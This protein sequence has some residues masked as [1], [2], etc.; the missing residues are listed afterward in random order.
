MINGLSRIA[1]TAEMRRAVLDHVAAGID[2]TPALAQKMNLTTAEMSSRLKAMEVAGQVHHITTKVGARILATWKIGIAKD[3]EGKP[4]SKSGPFLFDAPKITTVSHCMLVVVSGPPHFRGVM[5]STCQP[6][7]APR[8]APV[9][10]HGLARMNSARTAAD[11]VGLA[12]GHVAD[13]ARMSS[14][15]TAFARADWSRIPPMT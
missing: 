13:S 7:Q 2:S 3:E 4:L 12:S 1:S 10:G 14:T 5:W 6:G 15:A 11:L 9:S 8:V